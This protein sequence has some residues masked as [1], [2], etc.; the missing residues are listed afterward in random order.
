[1]EIHVI[2][3]TLINFDKNK[4]YGQLEVPLKESFEEEAEQ[5]AAQRSNDYKVVF[6][7]TLSRCFKLADHLKLG[8][9]K[10]DTRLLEL[11]FGD[12]EGKLWNDINQ[13]DLNHWMEDFVNV[14]PTNCETL[15]QMFERVSSFIDEVRNQNFE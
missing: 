5:L 10:T 4:C 8:T 9:V 15:N 14:P 7:S 6:S 2:R 1:M 13:D 3:H 11:D 12:W